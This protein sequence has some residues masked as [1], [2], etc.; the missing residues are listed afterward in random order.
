[1]TSGSAARCA[2]KLCFSGASILDC[3]GYAAVADLLRE[4]QQ[5]RSRE[6]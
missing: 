6:K 4:R 3:G 1:M 2:E 5:R